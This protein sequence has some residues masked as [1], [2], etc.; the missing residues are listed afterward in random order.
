MRWLLRTHE[1]FTL[2]SEHHEQTYAKYH[3]HDSPLTGNRP[4]QHLT[5]SNRVTDLSFDVMRNEC[6]RIYRHCLYFKP[7]RLEVQSIH[8]S[9]LGMSLKNNLRQLIKSFIKRCYDKPRLDVKKP[10]HAFLLLCD[11]DR[12]YQ[13]WRHGSD[14]ATRV[15]LPLRKCELRSLLHKPHLHTVH[16]LVTDQYRIPLC[17]RRKEHSLHGYDAATRYGNSICRSRDEHRIH[18]RI[19]RHYKQ[20]Q[21]YIYQYFTHTT[22]YF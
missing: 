12:I 4:W 7:H 10:R 17:T 8:D 6:R 22:I 13:P 11:L 20:K 18:L 19:S 2:L 15:I 3:Q 14:T 5:D 9:V 16:Q 1:D 21:K